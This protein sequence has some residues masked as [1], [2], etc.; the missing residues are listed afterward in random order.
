MKKLIYIIALFPVVVF[1]QT[2]TENYVKTPSYQ[3]EFT[4]AQINN[5]A[6]VEDEKLESITYIDGMGRPKQSIGLQAGGNREDIVQYIEYDDLGREAKQYLPYATGS[7][8]ASYIPL[9]TAKTQTLNFYNTL[10]YEYTTNPYS[11][12]VFEKST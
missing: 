8:L 3:Q 12:S 1:A 11:E 6:P 7:T 4:I 2:G 5:G 10:K 9:A